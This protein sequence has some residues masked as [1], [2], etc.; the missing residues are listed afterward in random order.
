MV[1]LLADGRNA[2]RL[3]FVCKKREGGEK[4]KRRSARLFV[5]WNERKD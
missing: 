5:L 4:G 3:V 1:V 2:I